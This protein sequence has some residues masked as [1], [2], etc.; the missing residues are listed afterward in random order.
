ML[1][2]QHIDKNSKGHRVW[3]N[4]SKEDLVATA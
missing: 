2:G 3:H 1:S 4:I